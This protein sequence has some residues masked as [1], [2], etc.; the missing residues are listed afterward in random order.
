[1]Y[2]SSREELIK[3]TF[4]IKTNCMLHLLTTS[5]AQQFTTSYH[6]RNVIFSV[7]TTTKYLRKCV[8]C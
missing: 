5:S 3:H 2:E 1:M 6:Q 4:L 8:S 7:A